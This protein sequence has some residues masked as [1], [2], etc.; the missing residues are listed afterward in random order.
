MR[1][2]PMAL[3]HA[4]S[5][6][7]KKSSA[8]RRRCSGSSAISYAGRLDRPHPC[9]VEGVPLVLVAARRLTTDY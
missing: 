5:S 7:Q 8:A 9:R 3:R 4:S 6:W 1:S 2:M